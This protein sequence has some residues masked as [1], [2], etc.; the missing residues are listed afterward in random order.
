MFDVISVPRSS[1]SSYLGIP[2]QKQFA[3]EYLNNTKQKHGVNLGF[4]ENTN[5]L[6]VLS[7]ELE[8]PLTGCW[9]AVYRDM[10]D[11]TTYRVCLLIENN[12]LLEVVDAKGI[13]WRADCILPGNLHDDS[14]RLA[15]CYELVKNAEARSRTKGANESYGN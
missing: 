8:K 9:Q 14:L 7:G 13:V 15:G 3:V 4:L 1:N 6:I 10:A 11:N 2:T 5:E 12:K